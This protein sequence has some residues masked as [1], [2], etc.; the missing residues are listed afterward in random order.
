MPIKNTAAPKPGRPDPKPSKSASPLVSWEDA[1]TQLT[2]RDVFMLVYG[3]TS[4]GRTTFALSAPGPIAYLHAAE[5]YEGIIQPA[6]RE[7]EIKVH[8]FAPGIDPS[9]SEKEIA[10]EARRTWNG[11]KASWMD[12]YSWARTIIVDTD[13]DAWELIRLAYFGD[14]KP[15]GGRLELNWGP[16][17]SEWKTLMRT[18]KAQEGT[19]LILISQ[20]TDEYTKPKKGMGERT[21]ERVRTG[22]K[23]IP[24]MADVVVRTECDIQTQTYSSI[25]EK[26]WWNGDMLGFELADEDS[27]FASLMSVLTETDEEEW[28]E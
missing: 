10:A 14:V 23:S 13:T 17:N 18:F 21:G 12:A 15:A 7:K 9:L 8:N 25:V 27:N 3:D 4:S 6:A 26:P 16:V 2:R 24:Y 11:L 22:Q 28:G 5:K 19:N 20:S 1:P